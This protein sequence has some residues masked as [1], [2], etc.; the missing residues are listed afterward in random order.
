[1]ALVVV[2]IPILTLE[3]NANPHKIR[4]YPDVR[5]TRPVRAIGDSDSMRRQNRALVL[6]T[7][8]TLGPQSRTQLAALT[9]LSHASIT[10]ITQDMGAQD[11]L[12]D[13]S[14]AR[15]DFKSRGRPAVKVG[16]SRGLASVAL[17]EI[18]VARA[19]LSL[20]G[21]DGTLIDR[22]EIPLPPRVFQETPPETLLTQGLLRLTERNGGEM[23]RLRR[24]AISVQGLLDPAGHRLTWSPVAQ[25]AG[26]DLVSG[27]GARFGVPVELTKRGHLLAQGA[28]WMDASLK[29]ANVATVFVGATVAMGLSAPG[30][31]FDRD[32]GATEFGHMNHIPG[33]ALCRCGMQGCIEA[34]AADYAILRAAYSVPEKAPPAP[35][36]P[37]SEFEALI[38]RGLSGD[39]AAVHAFNQA[40]RAIG[41]GLNRLMALF[42]PSHVVIVGPGADAYRLMRTELETAIGNSL[43]ARH[44]GLPEIRTLK[45]AG[46]PIF[47]GL[48]LQTLGALDRE[49]IASLPPIRGAAAS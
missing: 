11:V 31:G 33:G 8:R 25:L 18:E 5:E 30:L 42:R 4:H 29:D 48:V 1:M 23:A 36:V 14:E 17:I 12:V 9:G 15:E 40:G 16:F 47:H 46:E 32:A 44:S 35:A 22:I 20:V 27:L 24:I 26:H 43:V 49:E 10:A 6:E 13:L 2:S 38:G 39:R 21:Y 45:D 34:Y 28:R 7:L 3:K 19:R 37:P 41:Y